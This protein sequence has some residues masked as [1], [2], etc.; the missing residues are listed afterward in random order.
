M[1]RPYRLL[2]A[3]VLLITGCSTM[4]PQEFANSEPRLVVE[5]CHFSH[6]ESTADP[7]DVAQ[8]WNLDGGERDLEARAAKSFDAVPQTWQLAG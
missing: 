5:D 2:C 4:K 6:R 3:A 7:H 8:L 1:R